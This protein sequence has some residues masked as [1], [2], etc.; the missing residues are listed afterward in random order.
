MQKSVLIRKYLPTHFY[1]ILPGNRKKMQKT[2]FKTKFIFKGMRR[3]PTNIQTTRKQSAQST[4]AHILT[5]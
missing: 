4:T 2:I 3:K 1:Q 5:Q